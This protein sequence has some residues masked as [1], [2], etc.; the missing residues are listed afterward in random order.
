MDI[1]SLLGIE[2]D[3]FIAQI[4][5][6]AI[7]FFVLKLLLYKPVRKVMADRKEKISQGLKDAQSAKEK[8]EAAGTER[9]Q[10]IKTARIDA[11]KLVTDAKSASDA[12]RKQSLEDAR[13]Q[14]QGIVD[15]AKLKAEREFENVSKN[16]GAMSLNLSQKVVGKILSEIFSDAQK[17]EILNK[18]IDKIKTS[19][20]E[21]P[22][23]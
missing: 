5:N 8:L 13:K 7:L 23:N 11:D 9:A 16:A 20:Y 17:Q 3:L 19:N 22:S 12:A 14:S 4:V 15:D 6:F 2:L 21:Q 18:A 1:L 10:I